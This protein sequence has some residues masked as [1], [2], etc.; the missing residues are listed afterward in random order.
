MK[1]LIVTIMLLAVSGFESLANEQNQ[2]LLALSEE[3]RNAAF[4]DAARKAGDCDRVVHSM[5]LNDDTGKNMLWSVG[6]QNQ[7]TYA[8]TVYADPK[9]GLFAVSCEDLKDFGKMLNTMERR[10]GHPQNTPVAECWKKF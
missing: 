7:K 5:Q 10:A 2:K 9:F 8:V 3:D 4:A 6:C 1:R